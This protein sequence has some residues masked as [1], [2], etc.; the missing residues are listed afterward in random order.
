MRSMR[1]N[2]S[3]LFDRHEDRM[4]QLSLDRFRE[5]ALAM[6]VFHEDHFA[7]AD[8][9]GFAVTGCDRNPGVEID[10]VLAARSRMP[11]E[12]LGSRRLAKDDSSGR[13]C[14]RHLA[15]RPVL[16]LFDLNVAEMRFARVVDIKIVDAHRSLLPGRLLIISVHSRDRSNRLGATHAHL[17]I[18]A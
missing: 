7:R 11:V 18:Q 14:R 4:A 3:G 10:D 2:C 13:D 6:G 12:I 5:V 17:R 1:A 16:D 9:P 8:N 15:A